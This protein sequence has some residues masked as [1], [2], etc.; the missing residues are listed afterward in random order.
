ML[1][2][3]KSLCKRHLQPT[4][5]IFAIGVLLM[6][7]GCQSTTET[8][9][10]AADVKIEDPI[11]EEN[12]KVSEISELTP[13]LM[14]DLLVSAIAQQRNQ[15]K[16]AVESL[17]RAAYQSRHPRIVAQAMRL[18]MQSNNFQEAVDLA[19]LLNQIDPENYR[20]TLALARAQFEL[21][22][23]TDALSLLIELVAAQQR[24]NLHVFHDVAALISQQS[25][26]NGNAFIL[27]SY[28]QL[29]DAYENNLGVKMTG[30]ILAFR[31]EKPTEFLDFAE[32][33][34]MLSADWEAPAILKLTYLSGVDTDEA[35][36][37]A[38]EYIAS[39]PEQ[40]R[41]RL[42]YARVLIQLDELDTAL[43]ELNQITELNPDSRDTLY[44]AGVV[45]LELEQYP[46]AQLSFEQ[47]FSIDDSNDQVRMY[48]AELE[49]LDKNY[50]SATR[51]LYGISSE[52]FYVD[53]Q[54]QIAEIIAE[55]GELKSA[56][57]HL[58]QIDVYSEEE[59]IRIILEQDYLYR[60]HATLSDAKEAL[61]FG[62]ERF[63]N[64]TE[65]LY[66]RGL[67]ATQMELLSLHE[68]DMRRLIEIEPE[69]AHAYNA[70]G[71]TLADKTDRLDEAIA[72]ITKAN[73]LLP[74][75]PFILDSMGWVHFRLGNNSEA[76]KFLK[77]ALEGRQDPEI[78]AHLGEV[79]WIIGKPEEA[80]DIW[81]KGQQWEPENS[82]LLDTI[83]RFSDSQS[84]YQPGIDTPEFFIPFTLDSVITIWA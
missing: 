35:K 5:G 18:A 70:L 84:S 31:L 68:S 14:Y 40:E 12:T 53:A 69:N 67:L 83:K 3:A 57:K 76:L 17:S 75:N 46:E 2:P 25:S 61:D 59:N 64:N 27:A 22:N 16:V 73:D 43:S 71:Y 9:Q 29:A 50:D 38:T 65:L 81:N 42:Q 41:F 37:F 78:A 15:N 79:L 80:R 39:N 34:L 60:K 44:T 23:Q 62:L 4:R 74:D 20:V 56:I 33:S 47:Y 7:S 48:L 58:E 26:K 21:D 51:Y 54:I 10:P 24:D 13:D 45:H 11:P 19:R 49:R 77:Q 52:Q 6:I 36:A 72:L 30:T 32:S 82:L 28:I 1:E 8:A 55:R 66:N 63:P